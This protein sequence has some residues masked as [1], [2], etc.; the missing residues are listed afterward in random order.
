MLVAERGPDAPAEDL[1]E[2]IEAEEGDAD[3]GEAEPDRVV[4][5]PLVVA[6]AVLSTLAAAWMTSRLF[7]QGVVALGVSICGI[8]IGA[9]LIYLATRFER[10]SLLLFAVLPAAFVAGAVF[11]T[12]GEGAGLSLPA[13]IGD[14]VR[15]GGLLQPPIPFDPGW[16]VIAVFLF[17]IVSSAACLVGV[18]FAR[19]KLAAGIPLPVAL[20][21][22]LLQPKG[23]ELVASGVAVVLLV[24][25]L[26][27]AYGADLASEGVS[28]GGFETRRLLRATALLAAVIVALAVVRADRPALP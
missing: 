23:S 20:G 26:A 24:G 14:A 9:G 13:L 25:A 6:S 12:T 11:A 8:A 17:A 4:H 28:S 27:I 10:S 15:G 5:A 18:T 16:R 7:S 3:P 21:A 22:A 1:D 2:I 19:P